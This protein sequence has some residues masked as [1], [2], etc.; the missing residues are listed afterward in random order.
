MLPLETC[1]HRLAKQR[2]GP[3]PAAQ[4]PR[5]CLAPICTGLGLGLGFRDPYRW[6]GSMPITLPIDQNILAKSGI[7]VSL[8]LTFEIDNFHIPLHIARH[9]PRFPRVLHGSPRFY[10][11]TV[12]RFYGSTLTKPGVHNPGLRDP[13]VAAAAARDQRTEECC[14]A[15]AG[16]AGRR[17]RPRWSRGGPAAWPRGQ[18]AARRPGPK[19]PAR[20]EPMRMRA[21]P[22]GPD[23]PPTVR[24]ST[25]RSLDLFAG[26][27]R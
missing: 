13:A 2:S 24:P 27:C 17:R 21:A 16:R 26:P 15:A 1:K 10:G 8:A 19:A 7:A 12:L 9:S 25:P 22:P 11:S 20:P 23:R 14:G 5:P 18:S 4:P 3:S 6:Y